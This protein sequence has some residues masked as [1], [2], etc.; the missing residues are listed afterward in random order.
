MNLHDTF[1][2]QNHKENLKQALEIIKI[3]ADKKGQSIFNVEE[4]Y[5]K[6]CIKTN[7]L[8]WWKSN[9]KNL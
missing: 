4:K 1:F 9:G 2:K 3:E 6:I 8:S 5:I 7:K